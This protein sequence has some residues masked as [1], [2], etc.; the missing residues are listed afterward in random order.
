MD[1][2][3]QM[4]VVQLAAIGASLGLLVLEGT[5]QGPGTI[6]FSIVIVVGIGVLRVLTA[7]VSLAM[8]TLVIEPIGIVVLLAGTGGPTSPFLPMALAGIWWSALSP[9]GTRERP[10]RIV[11]GSGA[12]RLEPGQEVEVGTKRPTWL[13]YG[14]SM[15]ASYALLVVLPAVRDG[16]VTEALEDAFVLGGVWLLAELSVFAARRRVVD[17]GPSPATPAAA[18]DSGGRQ[19]SDASAVH[20]L[21]P[22]TTVEYVASLELAPLTE[23]AGLTPIESHLLACLALG[24]SN[25]QIADL[26]QVSHGTVRYRLT[27]LYRSLDAHGRDEA[28]SRARQLGIALPID[29]RGTAP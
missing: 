7:G 10:F 24:M 27:R 13:V 28:V 19:P 22:P 17:N 4:A 6:G 2:R 3:A 8:S 29:L 16:V 1:A 12:L 20:Q 21:E 14:V 26:L 25:R 15:A 9:R 23:H 11:R 18:D 5:L